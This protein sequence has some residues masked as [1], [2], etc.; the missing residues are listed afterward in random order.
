MKKYFIIIAIAAVASIW[1]AS[2]NSSDDDSAKDM[3][4]PAIVDNDY[5]RPF[6]CDI[7]TRG[8]VIPVRFL[9][10]DNVE[11][12][13]FNIEIH[14]NFDHHSHST[15]A[16]NCQLD[17]KKTPVNPWVFNQDYSIPLNAKEYKTDLS[18]TIPKDIDTGDYH[19]MV[20]VTDKAG[21]QQIKA[22]SIKI[23]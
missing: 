23:K 16:G 13:N 10:R 18:I 1:I 12:G 19:F 21:W 17:D 9:F 4:K 22:V 11:L 20:R 8:E 15:S 6:E 2:C 3:E 5:E 14:N 7:Y